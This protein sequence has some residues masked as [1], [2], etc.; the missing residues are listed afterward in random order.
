MRTELTE[1][2]CCP[3]CGEALQVE[4]AERRETEVWRGLLRCLACNAT[5]PIEK[6]M[7]YLY[8]EDEAWVSKAREAAGWVTYHQDLGFY[9]VTAD[10]VDLKIPYYP[11][12]PWLSVAYSFDIALEHLQLT[13]AETILDLGAGRGWAARQFAQRGC[14]VVALDIVPDENVGLGRAHA[15]MAHAGVY[16]DRLIG[17]GENLP[18]FPNS[19]DIVFCSATL[20]HTSNLPLL[21][22]NVHK[23][24]KPG[25]RLCAIH[26]P[27]LS[28]AEDEKRILTKY[29]SHEL[30]L[31]INETRPDLLDYWQAFQSAHL[32]IMTALPLS[33]DFGLAPES[34]NLWARHTG[35]I[36]PKPTVRAPKQFLRQSGKYVALRLLAL[37]NGSFFSARRFAAHQNGG[38]AMAILLWSGSEMF[39]MACKR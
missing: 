8:V 6:G 12:E 5:Y 23:V 33:R 27:C 38:A 16:F 34:L 4:A 37:F 2:I 14:R 1:L 31:G 20:H 39:L 36:L 26:E 17:D 25:G 7:P 24:L 29:A 28:I 32:D 18:F 3:A 13:G 22:Q 30:K 19:F 10:S 15:L 11:E 35:A 21:L 9:E